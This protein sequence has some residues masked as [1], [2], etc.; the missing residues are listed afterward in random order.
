MAVNGQ[1][2]AVK[3]GT[4]AAVSR[5]WKAGD[6]IDLVIPQPLRTL[7]IDDQ[8]PNLAAVM[9]GAVMYVGVNP[10]EG[11]D[12]QT[13]ALPGALAPVPNQA[14]A[15]RAGVDGRALVFVP[16][17]AIDTASYHNYFN[18]ALV[19]PSCRGRVCKYSE[20]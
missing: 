20:S 16:Y 15:Y 12:N 11:I 5:T 3:P 4:L 17:Y 18:L 19:R 7:S 14:Q 10:W 8:T 1:Q 2:Q 9:R 6:T 13:I